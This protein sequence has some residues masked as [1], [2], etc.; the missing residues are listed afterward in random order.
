MSGQETTLPRSGRSQKILLR[1]RRP[2]PRLTLTILSIA[3]MAGVGLHAIS[4]ALRD[5]VEPFLL[6]SLAQPAFALHSAL[7]AVLLMPVFTLA[8]CLNRL[9]RHRGAGLSV[10]WALV[11]FT[12]MLTVP[13]GAHAVGWYLQPLMV[14]LMTCV[15]GAVPGLLHASLAVLGLLLGAGLQQAGHLSVPE[16]ALLAGVWLQSAVIGAVVVAMALCGALL[17]RTLNL[18][19]LAEE[20]QLARMDEAMRALRH[21][22]HLLRH[23]MRVETVGEV[24]SMVVHQLRNQLQLI[25]GYAGLGMR[26]CADETKGYFKSI[27]DTLGQTG[28][29]LESL[30]GMA[31]SEAETVSRIELV[32]F[33]QQIVRAYEQVLPAGICIQL[34]ATEGEVPVRLDTQGLEHALLNL[35][36]NARQA[37]AGEGR[38]DLRVDRDGEEA[39]LEVADSGSGIA[40]QHLRSIFKPFFTTKDKGKG[41]GL[42]LAAVQRFVTSSRGQIEVE[43]ELGRGTRFVMRFPLASQGREAGEHSDIA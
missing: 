41:T 24:S 31:R 11:A 28:E 30:L 35:V 29:L 32:E 16:S 27:V 43:S 12:L 5:G 20:D 1:R 3:G 36:I 39:V 33:A 25:M 34:R 14:L 19:I 21:R 15:F 18:A 10:S 8:F 4:L 6:T 22:E 42:G 38:I 26:R 2:R 7:P 40:E 37:I 13:R 23:A 9:G 17:H